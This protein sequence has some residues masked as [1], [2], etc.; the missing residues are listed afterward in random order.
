MKHKLQFKKFEKGQVIII[1]ALGL[2][3]LIAMSA[4]ILDGAMI[5][6]HRRTAQ[7]AADA[8]ALAGA[9]FLCPDPKTYN[10]DTAR[11]TADSY[12]RENYAVPLPKG[13][14]IL[15][16]NSNAIHV[17]AM[18]ETT[19]FFARVLGQLNLTAT[20]VAEA[21]CSAKI[22]AES[23]L[24]VAFPCSPEPI[25]TDGDGENDSYDYNSCIMTYYDESKDWKW[26]YYDGRTAMVMDSETFSKFCVPEE[27]LKQGCEIE[28]GYEGSATIICDVN[29]DGK[30]DI[31]DADRR[32]WLSLD[33]SPSEVDLIKWIKEGYET[34]IMIGT[35]LGAIPG[36]TNSVFDAVKDIMDPYADVVVPIVNATCD[37][38]DYNPGDMCGKLQA[39]DT[40]I[41]RD[42]EDHDYY[43]IASF[44]NFRVTCVHSNGNDLFQIISGDSP[45]LNDYE[46]Q[47]LID[48]GF[49]QVSKCPFYTRF[50]YDNRE[51]GLF[52]KDNMLQYKAIE[53]YF[54]EGSGPGGAGGTTDT[55]GFG[56]SLIK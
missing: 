25:D 20:A 49:S 2:V 6:S 5:M 12:V 31:Y 11:T 38:Y 19:S 15:P 30:N 51:N 52:D 55:G 43:R 17:E 44:A 48:L 9:K 8:G 47:E 29:C 28:D 27:Y 26:N 7:A 16:N 40:V 50:I 41:K 36:V 53:G 21:E 22:S 45:Y 39:G 33:G 56:I 46:E 10:A 42:G 35:W 32:G 54:F 14:Y 24:P 1:V 34:E 37:H 13:I 4:L 3:A 18:V 23:I